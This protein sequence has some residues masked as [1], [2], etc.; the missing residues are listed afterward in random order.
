MKCRAVQSPGSLAGAAQGQAGPVYGDM[1]DTLSTRLP[2][3]E[4]GD[5][6]ACERDVDAGLLPVDRKATIFRTRGLSGED[7]SVGVNKAAIP[8]DT[9]P[10]QAGERGLRRHGLG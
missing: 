8:P 1:V 2:E 3:I 7:V 10:R 6:K 9:A 5:G 4:P